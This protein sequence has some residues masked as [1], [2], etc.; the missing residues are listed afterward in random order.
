[1]S[2]HAASNGHFVRSSRPLLQLPG[3]KHAHRV[4][5]RER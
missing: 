1:M 2:G 3:S 5:L 4:R